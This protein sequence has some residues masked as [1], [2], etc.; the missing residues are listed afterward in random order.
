MSAAARLVCLI[1]A[2]VVGGCGMP[3]D[4][5][6][7]SDAIAA[8]GTI[9]IGLATHSGAAG[10]D[11][12]RLASHLIARLER[13]TG[14]HARIVRETSEPLLLDLEAGELDLV[15]GSFDAKTPWVKR[16]SFAPALA[17]RQRGEAKLELKAAGRNG[18]SRWISLIERQ[19][20][21]VADEAGNR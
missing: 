17:T 7:T 1:L 11:D 16:V 5:E 6:G 2:L 4:V 10:P 9:R 20:R 12:A 18:E 19:S 13:E 21:A 3:R 14:A 15:I 8:A